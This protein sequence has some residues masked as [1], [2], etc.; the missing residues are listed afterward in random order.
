MSQNRA[1]R[2]ASR[3]VWLTVASIFAFGCNPL[4]TISFLT[5]SDPVKKAEYPLTFEKGPKKGKDPVVVAVFVGSSPG[6]SPSFAGCEGKL[7]SGIAKQLPEMCKDNKENK[8]KIAVVEPSM[9]NRFKMNNP[10]WKVMHPSEWGRKLNVDFVMDIQLEKMSLYQ[11]NSCNQLYEGTAEVTVDIYDVDEGPAAEPKHHYVLPFRYPHTGALDA[12][13]IPES[14]FRQDYMEHL[15][16]EISMK[17][18]TCKQ[19]SGVLDDR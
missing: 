18:V 3:I 12:S 10:K 4:S 19:G 9:V 7:A 6:I 15:A 1:V 14:R 16:S 11:P 17:H 8:Q 2:W 5:Q 13:N